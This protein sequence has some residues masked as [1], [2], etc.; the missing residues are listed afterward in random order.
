MLYISCIE[1]DGVV[2]QLVRAPACHAGSCGF[3]SHLS[4]ILFTLIFVMVLKL[5]FRPITYITIDYP[6]PSKINLVLYDLIKSNGVESVNGG[7]KRTDFSFVINNRGE[8]ELDLLLSWIENLLPRI[9]FVF[10]LGHGDFDYDPTILGFNP[11]AFVI[12]ES[13]GIHYDKGQ[14][15]VKHNHFPYNMTFVYYIKTPEGSSPLIL[16]NE[17]LFLKEGQIIFFLGHQFHGVEK[18][19]IDSR[20]AIAGNILYNPK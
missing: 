6:D 15:V 9:A 3:K 11:E 13:W 14:G 7:A 8:E 16:D 2:V 1:R 18:N 20:C 17:E 5:P 4:R 10:A 19:N 12:S